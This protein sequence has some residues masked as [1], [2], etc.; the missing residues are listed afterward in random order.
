MSHWSY[1]LLLAPV[2]LL[3]LGS[4]WDSWIS[5]CCSVFW[6]TCSF[7]YEELATLYTPAVYR[8]NGCWRRDLITLVLGLGSSWFGQPTHSP[9]YSLSPALALIAHPMQ[10]KSKAKTLRTGSPAL[11]SALL[12]CPAR[13]RAHI[14]KFRSC[15]GSGSALPLSFFWSLFLHMARSR[16]WYPSITH[17]TTRWQKRGIVSA[18]LLLHPQDW[19]ATNRVSSI[20][21]CQTRSMASFPAL[22][23]SGPGLPLLLPPVWLTSAICQRCQLYNASQARGRA[24]STECCSWWEAGPALPSGTASEVGIKFLWP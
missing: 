11:E 1:S 10:Q 4:N 5:C 13:C 17:V 6:R 16:R 12:C 19:L 21:H 3:V 8:W 22:T 9:S 20:V 15:W 18:L 2:T 14:P 23:I 24:Y 7:G